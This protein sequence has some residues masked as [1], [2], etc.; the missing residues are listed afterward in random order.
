M[1]D[2][3]ETNNYK[4]SIISFCF[5]FFHLYQKFLQTIIYAY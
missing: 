3:N 1:T 2:H 5:M 4:R